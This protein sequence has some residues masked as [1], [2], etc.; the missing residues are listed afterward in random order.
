MMMRAMMMMMMWMMMIMGS[1]MEQTADTQLA[2][3]QSSKGET[4]SQSSVDAIAF[5]KTMND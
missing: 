1:D 4:S 2:A 3:A 5:F